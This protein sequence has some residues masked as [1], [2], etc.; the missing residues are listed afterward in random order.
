[1]AKSIKTKRKALTK[2]EYLNEASEQPAKKAKKAKIDKAS[3][4]T[5]SSSTIQEEVQ[6]LEPVKVLNKRTRSGKDVVPSPPQ[7]AQPSIPKRKRKPV[8]RKLKIASEEK[9]V[10]DIAVQKALQL[11]KEIEIPAEVLAKESTVEAA[12]LGLELTENLQQMAVADVMVEATEVV[13]EE[14]GCSEASNASEAPKGNFNSHTPPEII[15]VESSSSPESRSSSAS[16][17][18]SSS[19]SS[20]TDDVPLNRVYTNLNKALYPSPST[21]TH[22]KTIS[23]TFVPMYPSVEERLIGLQQ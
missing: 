19:T 8:V 11:A 18:S 3:E 23:D 17:S 20:D 14:A 12:Q 5:C 13:Q 2:D 4:A 1:V 6:D 15:T 22:K 7:P 16:L 10:E 9:E 21:K